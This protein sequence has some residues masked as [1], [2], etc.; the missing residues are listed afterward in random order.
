MSNEQGRGHY[1]RF[2]W[3]FSNYQEAASTPDDGEAGKEYPKAYAK[4]YAPSVEGVTDDVA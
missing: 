3:R 1:G 4:S 2:P